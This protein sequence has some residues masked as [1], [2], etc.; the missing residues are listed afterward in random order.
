VVLARALGEGTLNEP[1]ALFSFLHF[2]DI[3][4]REPEAK[5]TNAE[6]SKQLD[7]IVDSF[8]RSYEQELFSRYTYSAVVA[9]VN[10]E[11]DVDVEDDEARP[12][13]LFMVHTGDSVDA[14]LTSEFEDF[15]SIS[16][17]LALPWYQA[18]GNHDILAFGN[19]RLYDYEALI[20]RVRNGTEHDQKDFK[21]D[22]LCG[23]D[24]TAQKS[25]PCTCTQLSDLIRAE[26]NPRPTNWG[27]EP[28]ER[29]ERSIALAPVGIQRI[30]IRHEVKGDSFVMDPA[31]VPTSKPGDRTTLNAFMSAHCWRKP[32]EH[33]GIVSDQCMPHIVYGEREYVSRPDPDAK[34]PI[35]KLC[36][37]EANGQPA[38][39]R[40]GLDLNDLGTSRSYYC[41]R[42]DTTALA[43][44]GRRAYAI[45]LDTTTTNGAYGAISWEQRQWLRSVLAHIEHHDL[46][47]VFGHHPLWDF[48]SIEDSDRLKRILARHPGVIGYFDGHTHTPELRVAHVEDQDDSDD[49]TYPPGDPRRPAPKPPHEDV[50]LRHFW[51][52]TA[53]SLIAHPQQVRQ[54][55]IKMMSDDIGY[56]EILSFSPRGEKDSAE[57]IERGQRGAKADACRKPG[58]CENGEPRQI[59]SSAAYPR[60]FFRVPA[61]PTVP[62]E[63]EEPITI[64]P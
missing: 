9:T 64:S 58:S 41:F 33:A 23:V 16:N 37:S 8:E 43:D 4:I 14:G 38:S 32:T 15:L 42:V 34:T 25:V 55:T 26:L 36:G 57:K 6:A 47:M 7:G 50:H 2:S 62:S 19:M 18:V 61:I 28:D 48:Y 53:P 27:D 45:V 44:A 13:P 31:R 60:L 1:E 20:A 29:D 40:H 54:V 24:E 10:E 51:D 56:I 63:T 52:I 12:K 35:D 22:A 49:L 11:L 3:Q 30:C 5:L 21:S 46:V 39:L 17:Q 59:S